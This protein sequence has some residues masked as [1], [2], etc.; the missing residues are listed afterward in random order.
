MG[1][2][3]QQ[4]LICPTEMYLSKNFLLRQEKKHLSP[5]NSIYKK[6]KK[7]V[8]TLETNEVK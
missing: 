3:V 8:P 1:V 7:L 6:R 2:Q 5:N 4:L